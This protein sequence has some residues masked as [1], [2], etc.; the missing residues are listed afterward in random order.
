MYIGKTESIKKKKKHCKP[1]VVIM[2]VE[3]Y[4]TFNILFTVKLNE[5]VGGGTAAV[6]IAWTSDEYVYMCLPIILLI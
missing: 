4:Y 1:R 3:R 6:V 2:P 5:D